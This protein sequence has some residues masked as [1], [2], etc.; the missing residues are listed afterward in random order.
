MPQSSNLFRQ[1]SPQDGEDSFSRCSGFAFY[2]SEVEQEDF[3]L[4]A[5][6]VAAISL[7]SGHPQLGKPAFGRII[8]ALEDVRYQEA[9]QRFRIGVSIGV[10][11]LVGQ[12]FDPDAVMQA[13]DTSCFA[14]KESG[15]NRCHTWGESDA[16]LIS[17]NQAMASS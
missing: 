3:R 9:E 6:S 2:P 11:P 1:E 15:R 12:G 16:D 4:V 10:V 5:M 17:R 8:R 14:A 13:A 7:S